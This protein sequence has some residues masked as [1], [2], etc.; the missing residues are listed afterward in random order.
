MSPSSQD[1]G[2]SIV[3]R[4]DWRFFS[5]LVDRLG[6]RSPLV[7][8]ITSTT[9]ETSFRRFL[10]QPPADGSLQTDCCLSEGDNSIDTCCMHSHFLSVLEK[11]APR[12]SQ[13]YLTC[14]A[15]SFVFCSPHSV[16]PLGFAVLRRKEELIRR[17]ARSNRWGFV[18]T[19]KD[20]LLIV[21]AETL[22]LLVSCT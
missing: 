6:L 13:F 10:R 3:S 12:L 14:C 1:A 21:T 2:M 16:F 9:D 15:P 5:R 19:L 18:R 22:R 4:D 7:R 11:A 20:R 8:L 17:P